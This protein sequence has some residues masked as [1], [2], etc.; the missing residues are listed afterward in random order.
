ML[1]ENQENLSLYEIS[2]PSYAIYQT[3]CRNFAYGVCAHET[4]TYLK[5]CKR[6]RLIY[7]CGE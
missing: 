6:K 4:Y 2:L 1:K 7:L 5:L 3:N